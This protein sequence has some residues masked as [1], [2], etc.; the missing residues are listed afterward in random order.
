MASL[1]RC[2]HPG[3]TENVTPQLAVA[4]SG[5]MLLDRV[6][7]ASSVLPR[8][9]TARIVP[10]ADLGSPELPV[11]DWCLPLLPVRE[12]P[13]RKSWPSRCFNQNSRCAMQKCHCALK[14][15]R[16]MQPAARVHSSFSRA[17]EPAEI[18]APVISQRG[19][20]HFSPCSRLDDGCS[21]AD[22]SCASGLDAP[23]AEVPAAPATPQDLAVLQIPAR[24]LRSRMTA[25][26]LHARCESL[27][28]DYPRGSENA[29]ASKVAFDFSIDRKGK[30][31]T[32]VPFPAIPKVASHR[33][34]VAP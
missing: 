10:V 11:S 12:F 7:V 26:L 21:G 17:S 31:R 16:R 34:P 5:G 27:H 24:Q 19:D 13:A 28:P 1:A 6:R 3:C 2:A 14:W 30:V 29:A 32:S 22:G 33:Q 8:H 9:T 15:P 23:L 20:R 4:A 25:S 18:A